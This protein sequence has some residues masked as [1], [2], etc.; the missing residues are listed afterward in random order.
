MIIHR[1]GVVYV[2]NTKDELYE[3]KIIERRERI[4]NNLTNSQV[5]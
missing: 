4:E 3:L 5:I 1:N 2:R